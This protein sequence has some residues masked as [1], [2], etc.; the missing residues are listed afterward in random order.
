M[1]QPRKGSH[2]KAGKYKEKEVVK[3][4]ITFLKEELV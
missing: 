2:I 4:D 3:E 1:L